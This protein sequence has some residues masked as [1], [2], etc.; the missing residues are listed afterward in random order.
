VLVSLIL[1]SVSG[2]MMAVALPRGPG[3]ATQ[4]LLL[5]SSCLVVGLITGVLL[6]TRWAIALVFAAHIAL[7]IWFRV[8]MMAE[9][10]M[11]FSSTRRRASLSSS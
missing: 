7:F 1:A 11:A 10:L 4:A 2:V 5:R 3:V 9:R 8:G 6:H